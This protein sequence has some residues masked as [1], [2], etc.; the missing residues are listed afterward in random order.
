ML[1]KERIFRIQELINLK[2]FISVNELIKEL[3]SSRS[4]IVRDLI[5]L[6]EQ[7]LVIRERGGASSIHSNLLLSSYTEIAVS[8][9]ENIHLDEK[10]KVCKEAA[11]VVHDGDCIYIDSGTTPASLI[12]FLMNK[13]IT[14]VTSSLYIIK[15]IPASFSGNVYLVGGLFS[16]K[17]DMAIG[18]M[19]LDILNQFNFDHAFFSTNGVNI[20][21]KEL[22]TA[23]LEIGSIKKEVLKRSKNNYV[24]MD[25]SKLSVKALYTWSTL[26]KFKYIYLN[27]CTQIETLPKQF[28]ICK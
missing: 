13:E 24:L 9:K 5:H 8:D 19:T 22:Y 1:A 20:K 27:D 28:V 15:K 7:G 21:T 18:N 10:I 4:S 3:Q 12:P 14:I 23:E 26:D 11:K 25:H 16:P 2:G 17:Y 6:E